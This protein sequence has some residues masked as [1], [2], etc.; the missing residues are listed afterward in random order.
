M[1]A[2]IFHHSD[3]D[4]RCAAW[5]MATF[6]HGIR[7]LDNPAEFVE[8]DYKDNV[9]V[10]DLVNPGDIVAIVDFSFPPPTM[11]RI[12]ARASRV[13]W[14]D[15]HITAKEYGYN[16]LEGVRDFSEKGLSGCECTWK[17][18]YP[19]D[20]IPKFVELIGDYDSWRLYLQPQ[21][22]QF[23]EGLKLKNT[24]PTS[25]LWTWLFQHAHSV[26]QV[27]DLGVQAIKYRDN[28]CTEMRT[29]FGY[30][31]ELSGYRAYAMNLYR[32]GSKQFGP[33]FHEYPVCLAYVHD[34]SRFVVSLYSDFID[35]SEI[36][37]SFG[38]GG[39]KG[40]AGF[41]CDQLP[42]GRK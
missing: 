28:Y 16:H 42:F 26:Q 29:A 25:I 13:I 24:H 37:K 39:H 3:T 1:K 19:G 17:F 35:V 33:L 21:C 40:A 38:G 22:F 30:E 31:T 2:I 27:I 9:A 5:I 14:C 12:Q 8:V 18:C 4:G 32:F 11:L 15:H 34:G 6:V 7:G 20:P 10:E 41:I 36:A 23:F